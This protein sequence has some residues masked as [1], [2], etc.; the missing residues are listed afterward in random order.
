MTNKHTVA[1]VCGIFPEENNPNND[2]FNVQHLQTH[3][4]D[5][6]TD[7]DTDTNTY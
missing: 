4:V 7:T 1:T 2:T 3:H 6:D 5:S